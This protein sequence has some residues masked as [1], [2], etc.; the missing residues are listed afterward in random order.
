[1]SKK[2]TVVLNDDATEYLDQL[3]EELDTKDN[4]EVI[5]YSLNNMQLLEKVI[6]RVAEIT[7]PVDFIKG[8]AEGTI[9]IVKK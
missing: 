8:I 1:M 6:A 4:S 5:N 3:K 2:I 7:D 9:I